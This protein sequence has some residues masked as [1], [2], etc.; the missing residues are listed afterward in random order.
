M[1][2]RRSSRPSCWRPQVSSPRPLSTP[3]DLQSLAYSDPTPLRSPT[4]PRRPHPGSFPISPLHLLRAE[5]RTPPL[6]YTSLA[7]DVKRLTKSYNPSVTIETSALCRTINV[8]NEAFTL[9][10]QAWE[11]S[12]RISRGER[13]EGVSDGDVKHLRSRSAGRPAGHE[14]QRCEFSNDA[15]IGDTYGDISHCREIRPSN[16][17]SQRARTG[18]RACDRSG[19]FVASDARG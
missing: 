9:A 15:E 4:E 13:G 14:P 10:A 11:S 17:R 12:Y 1:E 18:Q 3:P 2:R 6:P 7:R 16:D 5:V 8:V 19:A